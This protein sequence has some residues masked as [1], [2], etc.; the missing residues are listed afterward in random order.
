MKRIDLEMICDPDPSRRRYAC[1]VCGKILSVET[2]YV[3][4]SSW[5]DSFFSVCELHVRLSTARARLR[6]SLE[7]LPLPPD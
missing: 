2:L 3:V 6:L 7:R 4:P 1:R 5:P